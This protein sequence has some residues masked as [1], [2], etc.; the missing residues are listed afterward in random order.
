[1][2]NEH[3][4][5]ELL[6]ISQCKQTGHVASRH[7]LLL[8]HRN[9]H[10][11]IYNNIDFSVNTLPRNLLINSALKLYSYLWNLTLRNSA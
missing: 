1:M 11:K 9:S 5:Q 4:V 8:H 7:N 6:C 3:Y 10:D 2:K